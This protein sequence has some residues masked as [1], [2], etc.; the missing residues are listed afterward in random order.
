MPNLSPTHHN[1]L[2]LRYFIGSTDDSRSFFPSEHLAPIGI[3]FSGTS[4]EPN[5][6]QSSLR[7]HVSPHLWD[8]SIST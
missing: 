4:V 5:C 7:T 8:I 6:T 3:A 1:K 2:R